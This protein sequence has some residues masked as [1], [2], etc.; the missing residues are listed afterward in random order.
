MVAMDSKPI[1]TDKTLGL[2]TRLRHSFEN[3]KKLPTKNLTATACR[4]RKYE[5][6]GLVKGRSL[7]R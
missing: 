7:T 4:Q 6:L 2:F 1:F 5:N 3:Q